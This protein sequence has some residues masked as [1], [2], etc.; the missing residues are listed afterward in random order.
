MWDQPW[1]LPQVPRPR[2]LK[3]IYLFGSM[4]PLPSSCCRLQ[5]QVLVALGGP[6][7]LMPVA[8]QWCN[9]IRLTPKWHTTAACPAIVH[10][11]LMELTE[12]GRTHGWL[13]AYKPWQ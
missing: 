5:K 10:A 7:L 1:E 13:Q 4:H 11:L 8:V 12:Q 6:C 9:A 2:M 3:P